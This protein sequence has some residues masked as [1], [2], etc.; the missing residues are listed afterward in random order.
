MLFRSAVLAPPLCAAST[1]LDTSTAPLIQMAVS[2][3]MTGLTLKDGSNMRDIFDL[4]QK[5]GLPS[6]AQ[7]MIEFP[8]PQRLREIASKR[9]M[10]PGLHTY[11]TR[12]GEGE[13]RTALAALVRKVYGE[14]NI[15][16]DNVLAVAGVAGGVSAALLHLRKQKPDCNF[17]VLEPSY[18]YHSHEVERAF[19]RFPV[20]IPALGQDAA[21]NWP[22]LKRLVEANEVHGV[23]VTNPLNP[24]GK[25][26]SS[27]E[28]HMLLGLADS[29]GLFVIFDE[30]YLDM[31]FGG[32]KHV[33]PFITGLRDNVVA[34]RGFSKCLGCQSWRCGNGKIGRAHV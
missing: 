27:E 17:A 30:C 28:I 12:M 18:T 26:Y 11:R 4:C 20:V 21:P 32:N 25:V 1:R 9:V 24:T 19:G 3:E 16:P 10:E 14:E 15:T 33:S 34:C 2:Q 7:G 23:I 31:V 22:E 5:H 13:Y 6:L 8:P 29:H